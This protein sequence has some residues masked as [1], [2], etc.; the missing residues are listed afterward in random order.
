MGE[1]K[2]IELNVTTESDTQKLDDVEEQSES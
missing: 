2:S 1:R